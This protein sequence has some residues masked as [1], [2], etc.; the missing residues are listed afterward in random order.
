MQLSY[1]RA[2]SFD[3]TRHVEQYG[4][5]FDDEATRSAR[6]SCASTTAERRRLRRD[7][8]RHRACA[9]AA[10]LRAGF[11]VNR[12]LN[13]YGQRLE[14][15]VFNLPTNR[16][17]RDFDLDFRPS[18]WSFNFGLIVSP[19]ETLNVAAVYKTPFT[20]NVSLDKARRDYYGSAEDPDEITTNAWSSNS[21]RLDF[22]S[23]FGFGLSWR[24]RER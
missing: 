3:G 20:A 21:V 9:S 14:R 22:P 11:T 12:W 16:P 24:P 1:Q 5:A 10:T 2:I 4:P 7:R 8:R 13:G 17:R 19:V 18:G 6:S 15:S 23:S